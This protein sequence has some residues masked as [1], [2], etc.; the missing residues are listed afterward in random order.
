MGGGATIYGAKGHPEIERN[1]SNSGTGVT[2]YMN[3]GMKSLR[4]I[5]N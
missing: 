2:D 4:T 3:T 5:S 1:G